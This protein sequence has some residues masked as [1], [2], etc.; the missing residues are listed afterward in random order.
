[1]GYSEKLTDPRWQA[2]RLRVMERDKFACTNCHNDREQ[3]EVHH[4]DY[5]PGH[6][7]WEYPIEF[8]TTLCHR[9]HEKEQFRQREEH[10]LLTAF[11]MA[12]F[13]VTE[14]TKL[15]TLLYF[16]QF[17]SWLKNEVNNT[18]KPNG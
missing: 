13:H 2:K 17:S 3:L 11:K 16:P 4:L 10:G 9:C 8:L 15:K 1:M 7:P 5:E 14:L 12:G 6:Q 18:K